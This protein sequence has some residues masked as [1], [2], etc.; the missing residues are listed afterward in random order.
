VSADQVI[1]LTQRRLRRDVLAWA[2]ALGFT[3]QMSRDDPETVVDFIGRCIERFP[4]E[5]THAH[6]REIFA[7]C[8]QE[9]PFNLE[10]A[11]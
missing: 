5:F 9:A 11:E 8:R 4:S 7:W 1:D 6:G 3:P 2:K 10:P